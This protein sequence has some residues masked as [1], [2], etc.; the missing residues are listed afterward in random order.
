MILV[1]SIVREFQHQALHSRL[2]LGPFPDSFGRTELSGK[3]PKG[4]QVLP[5][6]KAQAGAFDVKE[7]PSGRA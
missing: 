2:P 1:G 5:S 6:T 7:L 4:Y 3:P